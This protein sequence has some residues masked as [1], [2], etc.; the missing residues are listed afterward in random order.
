MDYLLTFFTIFT[1][2]FQL[3]SYIMMFFLFI[4]LNFYLILSLITT[5]IHLFFHLLMNDDYICQYIKFLMALFMDS[6]YGFN[7]EF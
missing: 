5:I 4:I 7:L 6:F 3:I 2:Q 1:L